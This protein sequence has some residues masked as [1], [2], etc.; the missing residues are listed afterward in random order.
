MKITCRSDKDIRLINSTKYPNLLA[1]ASITLDEQFVVRGLTVM[2]GSKGAFVSFPSEPYT[3]KEGETEYRNTAFPIDAQL[4]A[5]INSTVLSAY[6][7]ARAAAYNKTADQNNTNET[8]A[9]SPTED[10]GEEFENF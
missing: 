1:S 8:E 6:D 4:R 5:D 9:P 10:E 3:N 7:K 2:N